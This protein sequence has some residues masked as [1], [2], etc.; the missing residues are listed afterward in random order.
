ML[1]LFFADLLRAMAQRLDPQPITMDLYQVDKPIGNPNG[2]RG[3]PMYFWRTGEAS[4][5]FYPTP[6]GDIR[7]R[8][9]QG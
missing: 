8:I 7:L 1:R 2:L 4:V 6:D 3:C 5:S 9:V